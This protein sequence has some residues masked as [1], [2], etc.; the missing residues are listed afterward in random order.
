MQPSA[1]RRNVVMITLP[2]YNE[3]GAKVDSVEVDESIFGSIVRRK[4]LKLAVDMYL[5]NRRQGTVATKSRGMVQG[6]T[7]KLFRQKGTG[8]ARM[9]TN[10]T[11]VRKGGGV[12]FAKVPKDWSKR[13]TSKSR[14]LARNSAILSKMK[15]GEL[16][17]VDNLKVDSPKTKYITGVLQALK[18]ETSCLIGTADYDKNVYLSARN[19][20]KISVLPVG[21]FNAYDVLKHRNMV[22]TKAGLDKL[23]EGNKGQTASV[24]V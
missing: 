21:D 16:L 20:T 12:A 23:V 3:Q 11:N 5:A 2:V 19:I 7:R 24:N 17:V 9:G 6:S 13:M 4:L 1:Y 10:R 15:D 22:I 18:L 14:R 8:R